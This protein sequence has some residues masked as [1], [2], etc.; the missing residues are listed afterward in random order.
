MELDFIDG[1]GAESTYA[2]SV[3][4]VNCHPF[5]GHFREVSRL[6]DAALEYYDNF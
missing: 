2:I 3:C 4:T 5:L 6:V 1:A